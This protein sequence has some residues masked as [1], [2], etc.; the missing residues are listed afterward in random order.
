[1]WTRGWSPRRSSRV[2]ARDVSH[3]QACRVAE[4]FWSAFV[5]DGLCVAA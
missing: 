3:V 2:G 4:A 1:M 5:A